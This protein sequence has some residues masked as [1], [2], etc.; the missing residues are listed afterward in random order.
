MQQFMEIFQ[1]YGLDQYVMIGLAIVGVLLLTMGYRLFHVSVNL[2]G[3]VISGGVF[4]GFMYYMFQ[5][6]TVMLAVIFLLS[7]IFG[8]FFASYMYKAGVFMLS[9]IMGGF[10]IFWLTHDVILMLAGGL[11]IAIIAIMVERIFLIVLSSLAGSFLVANLVEV[12][13]DYSHIIITGAAVIVAI[14]G[15]LLQFLTTKNKK[16]EVEEDIEDEVVEEVVVQEDAV[17]EAVQEV[18]AVV[19]P[20]IVETQDVVEEE[21]EEEEK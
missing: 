5:P 11:L 17:E 21:K 18:A 14:A 3:F 16:K 20:E 6:A 10:I 15:M 8:A 7:G 4:A 12:Y 1:E 9:G 13:T 19:E 2:L